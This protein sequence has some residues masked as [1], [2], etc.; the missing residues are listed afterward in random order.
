MSRWLLGKDKPITEPEIK[1][2]SEEQMQCTP[3]GQVMLIKGA[4]SVY[5]LNREYEKELAKRRKKMWAKTGHAEMLSRVRKI[6]G[7]RRREEIPMPEEEHGII[8]R[9][10]YHIKKIIIKPEEGIYLP[11]LVFAPSGK[12]KKGSVIYLHEKGKAADAAPG[13]PIEKMV[14][15]GRLVMAVD[16]RGVGETHGVGQRYFMPYFGTDGQDFYIAYVL[17]RS[18][19]GMR[20]EDILIFAGLLQQKHPGP[21]SLIA[22]GHVGIP[23]LHAAALEP[24]MFDSVKLTRTLISWSNVVE[25][26]KSQDQLVNTVH[27][28]L[29]V[30]DLPNLAETLGDKLIIEEPLDAL[31][32]SIK[33]E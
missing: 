2:I 5:D 22:I 11:A 8:K 19:V 26:G 3:E 32:K 29:T 14:K 24:D 12:T 25:I 1:T 28:A 10:G 4:C 16:L 23:A 6:A 7:I 15:A 33:V 13:G 31:G 27:G 20:A 21:I 30:Y 17:G 9:D 18:Y